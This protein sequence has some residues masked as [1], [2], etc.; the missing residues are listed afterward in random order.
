MYTSPIE[1]GEQ[2]VDVNNVGL[3]CKL[4][5]RKNS[6]TELCRPAA[7]RREVSHD[8]SDIIHNCIEPVLNGL[9][10]IGNGRIQHLL[11]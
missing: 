6:V 3:A 10:C 4:M 8:G 5:I 2:A 1:R 11:L 9:L 7:M